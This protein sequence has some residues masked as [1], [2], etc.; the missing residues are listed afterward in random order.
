MGGVSLGRKRSLERFFPNF[1]QQ[2]WVEVPVEEMDGKT[3]F[4]DYVTLRSS[5]TR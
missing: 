2:D 4:G 5:V 3:K 1:H